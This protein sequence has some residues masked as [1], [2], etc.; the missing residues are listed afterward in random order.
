MESDESRSAGQ[1][2][3]RFGPNTAEVER[4]IALG[5]VA[6]GWSP[7][8]WFFSVHYEKDWLAAKP[9]WDKARAVAAANGL[10]AEYQLAY[11]E[12]YSVAYGSTHCAWED[13]TFVTGF[14]AQALVVRPF[15][16]QSDFDRLYHFW[17]DVFGPPSAATIEEESPA[18]PPAIAFEENC[19]ARVCMHGAARPKARLLDRIA[20]RWRH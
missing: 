8:M 9:F 3:G 18:W 13:A 1:T 12:G 5:Q 14:T 6:G 16:D 10:E 2:A 19:G 7:V 15:L 4:A 17:G 20:R 11:D